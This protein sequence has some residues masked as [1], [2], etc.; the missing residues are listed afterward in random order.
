VTT[1]A[2][3][4]I[5][6]LALGKPV[7]EVTERVARRQGGDA[8]LAAE[9][10]KR[11]LERALSA[12]RVDRLRPEGEAGFLKESFLLPGTVS[13]R[14]WKGGQLDLEDLEPLRAHALSLI[15]ELRTTGQVPAS[16]L[17]AETAGRSSLA[18]RFAQRLLQQE[19]GT[20]T[21]EAASHDPKSVHSLLAPS[22]QRL[23]N[24]ALLARGE[25][26]LLDYR[27]KRWESLARALSSHPEDL[28]HEEFEDFLQTRDHLEDLLGLLS[29]VSRPAVEEP[30]RELDVRFLESTHP[31]EVSLRP[32]KPWQ[33]Q[34]W[35]WYRVPSRV[36]DSFK[37]RL[38]IVS[39]EAARSLDTD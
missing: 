3:T 24:A 9:S 35:W 17:D 25:V 5:G 32:H 37:A 39:P 11:S 26:L 23:I 8:E 6:S 2:S 28:L 36:G 30:V 18:M 16:L 10:V 20:E 34:R 7:S 13:D 21:L 33:P 27:I 1:T 12:L 4:I 19:E 15:E 29:P 22:D 31:V 14:H 38:A